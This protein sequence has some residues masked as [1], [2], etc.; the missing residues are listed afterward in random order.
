[1]CLDLETDGLGPNAAITTAS[2][3]DGRSI[4]LYIRGF[5]LECLVDDLRR[6][7]LI[8]TFNGTGF[9]MPILR[10][11]FRWNGKSRHLD[12]MPALNALGYRGSLKVIEV[13]R[14][15]VRPPELARTGGEAVELWARFRG[16]DQTALR[17]LLAYNA[18]DAAGLLYLAAW[19]WL[20]SWDG[21][22]VHVEGL[23]V[24]SYSE[25]YRKILDRVFF[26][27]GILPLVVD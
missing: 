24:V 5:N 25:V 16:G 8:I 18:A 21:F 6:A 4:R 2:T 15:M 10:R 26:D 1:L 27:N 13:A 11:T 3:Y 9:D 12:L 17:A 20:R 23:S 19:A 14:G 22:P 7:R